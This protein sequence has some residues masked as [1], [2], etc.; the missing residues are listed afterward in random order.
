VIKAI[1]A[2]IILV[3]G[4]LA[5]R[6]IVVLYA[7]LDLLYKEFRLKK[8]SFQPNQWARSGQWISPVF[9]SK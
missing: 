4:F 6:L 9:Q 1:L 7:A 3:N 8:P 5:C 2:L